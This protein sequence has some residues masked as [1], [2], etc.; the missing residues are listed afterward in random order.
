MAA[1]ALWPLDMDPDMSHV[2]AAPHV[3]RAGMSSCTAARFMRFSMASVGWLRD[4]PGRVVSA[5]DAEV[6]LTYTCM[7]VALRPGGSFGLLQRAQARTCSH[8]EGVV[9]PHG[10]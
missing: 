9:G 5:A 6:L 10:F 2:R 1:T 4:E 8:G 3:P 7:P